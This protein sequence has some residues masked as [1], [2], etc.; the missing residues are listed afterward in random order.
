MAVRFQKDCV[1][2]ITNINKEVKRLK[3]YVH[4]KER[5]P[6]DGMDNLIE[7]L[8]VLRGTNLDG[9]RD[10]VTNTPKLAKAHGGFA[11]KTP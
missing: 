4:E 1:E 6:V 8:S 7:L 9:A 3:R 2:L 5:W 10:K 11:T